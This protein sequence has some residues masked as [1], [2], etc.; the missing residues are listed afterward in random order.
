MMKDKELDKTMEA[1]WLMGSAIMA[2][3]KAIEKVGLMDEQLFLY[4]SDVDWAR[5]FWENG[6]KVVYYPLSKMYHYH[7]RE[8]KGGLGPLDILFNKQSRL[9]FIDALRYFKKYGLASRT[10]NKL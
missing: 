7:R 2:S 4:M 5:R 9:H 8:S 1:E 3:K 10:A 6:F